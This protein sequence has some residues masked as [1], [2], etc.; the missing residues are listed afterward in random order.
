M[1]KK[2]IRRRNMNN[3]ACQSQQ[4][5]SYGINESSARMW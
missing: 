1:K 4:I 3:W 5:Y 2:L